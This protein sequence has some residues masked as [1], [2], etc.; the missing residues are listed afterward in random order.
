VTLRALIAL[1]GTAMIAAQP[2][3]AQRSLIVT[4]VSAESDAP[5]AEAVVR[6]SQLKLTQPADRLGKVR[7]SQLP[8]P[9]TLVVAALG[10]LPETL[11]VQDAVE[12]LVRL[13]SRP[14]TLA[15]LSVAAGALTSLGPAGS[16]AWIMPA[17]SV[18][19]LPAAIEPDPLRALAAIPSV[20][21]SSPLSARP[22]VRGYGA[23]ET[24][25][26]LD[27]F[28]M[29]NP[30]HLGG[31]YSGFPADA[32]EDVTVATG[33]ITDPLQPGLGGTIDVRG[34]S[35]AA[36]D[37]P[38]AAVAASIASATASLGL[39][40]PADAFVA[41]RAGFLG[42]VTDLLGDRVA[43]AFQDAYAHA[44][45]RLGSG[46]S[47]DLTTYGSH[48]VL[49]SRASG[50]GLDWW[51]LLLGSRWRVVDRPSGS[52]D[53][54]ASVNRAAVFGA[55]VA[56]ANS[57]L[58]LSDRFDRLGVGAAGTIVG[59]GSAVSFGVAAD[60]R[61]VRS[62]IAVRWGDDYTPDTLD[63]RLLEGRAFV[64]GHLTSGS[65]RLEGGVSVGAAPHAA[66]VEPY[67]R[68]SAVL[69]SRAA[70]SVG[71]MRACRLY[72]FI[73]DQQAEPQFTYPQFWLDA[74]GTHVPVPCVDHLVGDF[75]Y[76]T[77][78]WS[79]HAGAYVSKGSGLAELRP[80][81]D[82]RTGATPFRFGSSRT[83]G[84][85]LRA[86]WRPEWAGGSSAAVAYVW[87]R[88]DR[89][90]EGGGWTPWLL[91]RRHTVRLQL[92]AALGARWRLSA[93]GEYQSG[94][95]VTPVTAVVWTY[96][97][98]PGGTALPSRLPIAYRYGPEGSA[99]SA[100]TLRC[101]VG[102][103]VALRGPGRSR[104]ELGFS[105]L[106]VAFGP[107]A[108][109]APVPPGELLGGPESSSAAGVRYVRRFSLPAIPSITGRIEF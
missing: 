5:V 75:D 36:R 31:A 28:E 32:T 106:N 66:R 58:D 87:A 39:R 65:A 91:D 47:W 6:S 25:I 56:A 10:F 69:S 42:E 40:Q 79:V 15:D 46:R 2:A 78:R 44:R 50:Q 17:A 88:S 1:L 68:L 51:S 99:R 98:A 54:I 20:T 27:G 63:A 11:V 70:V 23:A 89:R 85:E 94:Q 55:G 74:D 64:S 93:V 41:A 9:D 45:F 16:G 82:Q 12:L 67:G 77:E 37:A 29:V 19:T 81:T 103:R 92:E 102:A 4:V 76:A 59:A 57:S 13:G 53:V 49:G 34:R 60:W 109:D 38:A 52:L 33:S 24:V 72:Q 96:P 18:R 71:A 100:G 80:V 86:A 95:A 43:Y 108:P 61:R 107:V 101:D 73:S 22:L 21:F 97:P 26:R 84:M 30:Y 48:D 90:W 7:F 35:S 14:V 62:T 3:T 105:V 83:S 8:R 104:V